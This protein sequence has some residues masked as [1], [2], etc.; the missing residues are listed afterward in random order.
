MHLLHSRSLEPR[1]QLALPHPRRALLQRR[2]PSQQASLPHARSKMLS[3]AMLRSGRVGPS[4]LASG[5]A[6]GRRSA[7][8]AVARATPPRKTVMRRRAFPA[9]PPPLVAASLLAR[10]LAPPRM[11]MS[12]QPEAYRSLP[13]IAAPMTLLSSPASY[14]SHLLR[15]VLQQLKR[16]LLARPRQRSLRCYLCLVMQTLLLAM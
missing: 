9:P 3:P 10:L 12:V 7:E 13:T 6:S 15:K 11:S 14:R 16:S 4:R 2:K 1:W 5:L 8:L